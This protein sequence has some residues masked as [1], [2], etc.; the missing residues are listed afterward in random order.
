MEQDREDRVPE[1]AEEWEEVA[2]QGEA[3]AEAE[4][5]AQEPAPEAAWAVGAVTQQVLEDTAC[6]RNAEKRSLISWG[7]PAMICN[8][9]NAAQ[10]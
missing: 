7:L 6:A 4:V 3:P 10:P 1:Q 8:V 5:W 9:P 2:A